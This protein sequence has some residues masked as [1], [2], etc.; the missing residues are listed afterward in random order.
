MPLDSSQFKH[1]VKSPIESAAANSLESS[2]LASA[3][4]AASQKLGQEA[5]GDSSK[6]SSRLDLAEKQKSSST[7]P[8]KESPSQS[9]LLKQ[10]KLVVE[11]IASG[12]ALNSINGL[13]QFANKFVGTDFKPIRLGNQN[14]ID[15]S[16][17]GNAG[18]MIGTSVAFI[19]LA[20]ATKRATSFSS[21][22][23]GSAALSESVAFGTAGAIQGGLLTPTQKDLS[24]SSFF[25]ARGGEALLGSGSAVIGAQGSRVAKLFQ[26]HAPSLG[27]TSSRLLSLGAEG[28][29]NGALGA[30]TAHAYSYMQTG[31]FASNQ[32]VAT[33]AILSAGIGIGASALSFGKG[34]GAL[35]RAS[36]SLSPDPPGE[37]SLSNINS[38][39]LEAAPKKKIEAQ[40]K[41]ET[42]STRSLEDGYEGFALTDDARRFIPKIE[43]KFN[44]KAIEE[45]QLMSLLEEL[46][47]GQRNLA[48]KILEDGL[49][50]SSEVLFAQRLKSIRHHLET[51]MLEKGISQK[52]FSFSIE[53]RSG[54]GNA[55]HYLFRKLAPSDGRLSEV[56]PGIKSGDN[57]SVTSEVKLDKAVSPKAI[58]LLDEPGK[59]AFSQEHLQRLKSNNQLYVLD[60]GGF[61]KGLNF[62]DFAM[63]PQ[64]VKSKLQNLVSAVEQRRATRPQA[65]DQELIDE[66]IR[67]NSADTAAK[68]NENTVIV[69][70][71][72]AAR[73]APPPDDAP[74]QQRA[75]RVTSI[76]NAPKAS[77]EKIE[78]FLGRYAPEIQAPLA[79][80]VAEGSENITYKDMFASIDDLHTKLAAGAKSHG[81]SFD[82]LLFHDPQEND[83]VAL[84]NYMFKIRKEIPSERFVSQAELAELSQAGK[85]EEH[86]IVLLDDASYTGDKI[87]KRFDRIREF[88][89]ESRAVFFAL[90]RQNNGPIFGYNGSPTVPTQTLASKMMFG[91]YPE[92]WQGATKD[93][94][95]IAERMSADTG[96]KTGIN[97]D[98]RTDFLE[99]SIESHSTV[100]WPFSVPDNDIAP[101]RKFAKNVLG[102]SHIID[103]DAL[104]LEPLLRDHKPLPL[105]QVD[106]KL[107]HLKES[108]LRLTDPDSGANIAGTID[109]P[110]GTIEVVAIPASGYWAPKRD[111]V[112][113]R[114]EAERASRILDLTTFYPPT[115]KRKAEIDEAKRVNNPE[116]EYIFSENGRGEELS[117]GLGALSEPSSD[118]RAIPSILKSDPEVRQMVERAALEQMLLHS[119][120]SKGLSYQSDS[121]EMMRL[122]QNSDGKLYAFNMPT[123]LIDGSEKPTFGGIRGHIVKEF[124]QKQISYDT[125]TRLRSAYD[126]MPAEFGDDWGQLSQLKNLKKRMEWFLEH[127][128]FPDVSENRPD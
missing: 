70:A 75:Q 89:E 31:R 121:K 124:E 128:R 113:D 49:P 117:K 109:T 96:F 62:L 80:V 14:E 86:G 4:H 69:R 120:S 108:N 78:Q 100:I 51:D 102:V 65:S 77:T 97:G 110:D 118:E 105:S 24:G 44:V 95:A 25:L 58:V 23:L 71:Q 116:S 18:K 84:V 92:A 17:S 2:S 46:P 19:A 1:A 33:S 67:G 64:S 74:W 30:G 15:S 61:E 106:N 34:A 21:K 38:Q 48:V 127:R 45:A 126:R 53:D 93:Q 123:T 8:G 107:N 111:L 83:S 125:Y 22:I 98:P 82:D 104:P 112:R 81:L 5:L 27:V 9:D 66:V 88:S 55:L 87:G 76:I 13:T 52:S 90:M 40:P 114:G 57:S 59:V 85:L 50:N 119:K 29:F 115:V 35:D 3:S 94:L 16:L 54:W 79:Y 7:V 60:L 12:L 43:S 26:A 6:S 73:E 91:F 28:A 103:H 39:T 36:E 122:A 101:V 42:I 99:P 56:K 41:T 47:Q 68:L 37:S 63:G 20:L 32:E 10:P 72:D 11:G